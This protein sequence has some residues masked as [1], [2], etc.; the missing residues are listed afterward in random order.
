V[1]KEGF[2]ISHVAFQIGTYT[3][4][5]K[6]PP[7]ISSSPS[8]SPPLLTVTVPDAPLHDERPHSDAPPLSDALLLPDVTHLPT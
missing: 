3:F 8:S 1:T 2:Y 5:P 4:S 6:S 7:G